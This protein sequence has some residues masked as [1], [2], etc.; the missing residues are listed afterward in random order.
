MQKEPSNRQKSASASQRI[1]LCGM[2]A[3]LSAALLLS[4]GLIPVMT[5]AAPLL[6]GLLLIPIRLAFD[7][8]AA[9]ITWL[10]VALIVLMLG[11]DKEAAFFYLFVGWYPIAKWD[12]ERRV[13]KKRLQLL[14]KALLFLLLFAAMY[15]VLLFLIPVGSVGEDFAEMG[16]VLSAVFLLG[17]TACMLLYDRLI[18]PL[19]LMYV[20]RIQP[21]FRWLRR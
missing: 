16:R 9:W 7:R 2:L 10:A 17:L 20:Q 14:L 8:K 11:A 19:T 5:Y 6:S 4:S 15:A 1:A 18:T 3:A 13:R 12:I 21:R